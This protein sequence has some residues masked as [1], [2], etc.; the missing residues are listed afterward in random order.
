MHLE[1]EH[2][3]SG[4][5]AV[6]QIKKQ[7]STDSTSGAARL[8]ERR[9]SRDPSG[10]ATIIEIA[11]KVVGCQNT[12]LRLARSHLQQALMSNAESPSRCRRCNARKEPA[13]NLIVQRVQPFTTKFKIVISLDKR[14]VVFDLRP[15]KQFVD[16]WF[17][18][19][20]KA[21]SESSRKPHGRVCRDI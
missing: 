16:V 11:G 15:P 19:K 20:R 1:A 2:L 17:E 4:G 8:I 10:K 12:H 18:E 7:W 9:T 3:D 21:K 14:E 5:D 6:L 13:E